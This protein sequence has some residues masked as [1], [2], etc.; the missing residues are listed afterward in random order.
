MPR[1][2]AA[3]PAPAPPAEPSPPS[4]VYEHHE[5]SEAA[6]PTPVNPP[7]LCASLADFSTK[8]TNALEANDQ[9]F[10]PEPCHQVF[11][12]HPT[13]T[14]LV[15]L[16]HAPSLAITLPQKVANTADPVS[17]DGANDKKKKKEGGKAQYLLSAAGAMN[18]AEGDA[19]RSAKQR[20]V[21]RA[22]VDAVQDVDGY[23]YRR[24]YFSVLKEEKGWRG[25]FICRDSVQN[26]D[27]VA[28]A[29]TPVVNED[30]E[31]DVAEEVGKKQRKAVFPTYNCEGVVTVRLSSKSQVLE[32]TYKH[33]MLHRETAWRSRI[34]KLPTENEIE[35]RKERKNQRRKDERK[36]A[37]EKRQ[38]EGLAR[39]GIPK[40]RKRKAGATGNGQENGS[41]AMSGQMGNSADGN[42]LNMLAQ[43]LRAD[44][45][46]MNEQ[47]TAEAMSH[48]GSLAPDQNGIGPPTDIHATGETPSDEEHR[49]PRRRQ[50]G[51][52]L[53]CRKRKVKVRKHSL[54]PFHHR[55]V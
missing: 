51:G 21:A 55:T 42:N 53:M 41:N 29:Q 11:H 8:L 44:I 12:F 43:L 48:S 20:A 2:R 10:I 52:C 3:K 36:K 47:A 40:T 22:I 23:R 46:S 19:D 13:A 14:F 18:I 39:G 54:G 37:M 5:S 33:L 4:F 24:W 30:E 28:N 45:D 34:T 50:S 31:N 49:E 25:V 35:A 32:V 9:A 7:L 26:K 17:A 6:T 15:D 16:S 27:R 1:K 38:T